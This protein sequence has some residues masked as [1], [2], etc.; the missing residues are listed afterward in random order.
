[1]N[2]FAIAQATIAVTAAIVRGRLLNK[3]T[4]Q[5][6]ECKGT[7]STAP[8]C[9]ACHGHRSVKIKHAYALGY[10]KEW[11]EDIDESDGYCECPVCDG[12]SCDMC[13]GD[14]MVPAYEQAQQERRALIFARYQRIPPL[15][16]VD[17]RGR[18]RWDN[19]QMLSAEAAGDL[20]EAGAAQRWGSAFGDEFYLQ[21]GADYL[22]LWKGARDRAKA[23]SK[24]IMKRPPPTPERKSDE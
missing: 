4:V 12:H 22:T 16:T 8:D 17:Y 14:G 5:C 15:C 7:G 24:E 19:N 6:R 11:L 1:M 23:A 2:N 13:A 18:R 3:D 21:R 20:V 9:R 10:K